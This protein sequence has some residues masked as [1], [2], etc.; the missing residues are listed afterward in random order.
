MKKTAIALVA[1]LG[2]GISH[3][4]TGVVEST[5]EFQINSSTIYLSSI[6][7]PGNARLDGYN[8][9]TFDTSLGQ[10][11]VL[12]NWFFENYAYNAGSG[13][14][15]WLDGSNTATLNLS[16][17]SVSNNQT[18]TQATVSG[19]NRTWNNSPDSVNLLSGLAN[20]VYTLVTSVTYTYNDWNGSSTSVL[21]SSN[22]GVA[23]ATFTV[24]PEPAT[25]LLGALGTLLLF[26]RRK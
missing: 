17:S 8:L 23:T 3:G 5:G 21:T 7:V 20:G 10:T 15:N 9:G 4:A 16:I 1:I 22:N 12:S 13:S 14:D 19:N 2:S 25:S 6:G 24:V 11:L 18:L 26:R